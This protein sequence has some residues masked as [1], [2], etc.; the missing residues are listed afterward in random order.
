MSSIVE[1]A[2]I[3]TDTNTTPPA[4]NGYAVSSSDLIEG[5]TGFTT[6]P[7]SFQQEGVAGIAALTDGQFG[8]PGDAGSGTGQATAGP[9]QSLLYTLPATPE[10]L[11]YTITAVDTYAGWS[12]GRFGQAYDLSFHIVG[13]PA[14]MYTTPISV[15][16]APPGTPGDTQNTAVA[17]T[18]LGATKVDQVLFTFQ[19]VNNGTASGYAGYRELDVLGTAVPE[20]SSLALCGLSVLGL[21]RVARSRKTH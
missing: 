7:T 18:N 11:G 15:N 4:T 10:G 6:N 16:Y 9:T 3:A 2:S 20:P 5:L 13:T 21:L 1:A 19:D 17:I 14:G 8:T 12:Y